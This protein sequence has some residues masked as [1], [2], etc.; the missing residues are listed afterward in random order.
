M[1][2]KVLNLFICVSKSQMSNKIKQILVKI[3]VLF[4]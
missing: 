2:F 4:M 3:D 1:N